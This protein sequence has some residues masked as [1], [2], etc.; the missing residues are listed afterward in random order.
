[1]IPLNNGNYD[2]F[3][4]KLDGNLSAGTAQAPTVTTEDAADITV[5]GATLHGVVNAHGLTATAW[6]EYGD[7][8]GGPYFN[9][10]TQT[11]TGSSD[12]PISAPISGLSAG[13]KYYYRIVAEN[14]TGKTEGSE[15]TFTTSSETSVKPPIFGLTIITHGYQLYGAYPAWVDEMAEAIAS[16]FGGITKMPIYTMKINEDFTASLNPDKDVLVAMEYG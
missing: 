1:M 16:K 12:T 10:Q 9:T 7:T 11:V 5:D 8:S 13:T 6:F 4:S 3:V 2:V 15:K 14:T